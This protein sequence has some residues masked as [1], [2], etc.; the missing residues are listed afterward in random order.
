MLLFYL[1]KYAKRTK[2]LSVQVYFGAFLPLFDRTE[3]QYTVA[4]VYGAPAQPALHG[5]PCSYYLKQTCTKWRRI[6]GL[7]YVSK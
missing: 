5:H 1:S 2:H 7:Y 6:M 4:S 3:R